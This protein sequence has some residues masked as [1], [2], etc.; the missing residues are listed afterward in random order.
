MAKVAKRRST[1]A[2]PTTLRRV[3]DALTR[4]YL[5]G[6]SAKKPVQQT[7]WVQRFRTALAAGADTVT[8]V[9]GILRAVRF[10]S[11]SYTIIRLVLALQGHHS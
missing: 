11:G 3:E 9:D 2:Q 1:E 8:V 4:D 5:R 10:L 6:G 7:Q